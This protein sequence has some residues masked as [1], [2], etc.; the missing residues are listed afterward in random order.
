[1]KHFEFCSHIKWINDITGG[2]DRYFLKEV[3]RQGRGII[4]MHMQGIPQNMQKSPFYEDVVADVLE[5][6][7]S[8]A[9]EAEE[10]GIEPGKI[11]IDPG[12]GFGKTTEDNVKLLRH[13]ED[14]VKTRY[15][16]LL[17]VSRKSFL[18]RL[19]NRDVEQRLA[20][21]LAC[22]VYAR[23]LGVSYMRVHDVEASCDMLSMLDILLEYKDEKK[24]CS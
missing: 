10:L 9:K 12:I 15:P 2:R 3:Q 5:E 18:G 6:L 24:I 7:I 13:I 20:A 22:L 16:V 21:S 19:L 14:F 1:M 8:R 11:I 23:D 17:G 4:L